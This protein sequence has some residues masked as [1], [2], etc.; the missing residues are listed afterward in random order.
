MSSKVRLSRPDERRDGA[1]P[2]MGA[3]THLYAA[4]RYPISTPAP[5]GTPGSSRR[6]RP[7]AP[8]KR[9]SGR[10][11]SEPGSSSSR[12]QRRRARAGSRSPL[13]GS[14]GCS[15]AGGGDRARSHRDL[16]E[17]GPPREDPRPGSKRDRLRR[18]AG[19]M[20]EP[21]D[22]AV[23][24]SPP[25]WADRPR[26]R[27]GLDRVHGGRGAD[28]SRAERAGR[29]DAGGARRRARRRRDPG[30]IRRRHPSPR[31]DAVDRPT[32]ARAPARP[33]VAA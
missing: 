30:A 11:T 8:G 2:E 32:M 25:R 20:T 9:F 16:L 15:S 3:I 21:F 17:R 29:D 26:H 10:S 5:I 7:F 13:P 14:T 28:P 27:G 18:A 1:D 12:T 4:S 33:P 31:L 22:R 19:R 24:A 23:R 6:H